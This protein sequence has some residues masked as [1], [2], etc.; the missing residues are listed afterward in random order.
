MAHGT[1]PPAPDRNPAAG[2]GASRTARPGRQPPAR[3]GRPA[4]APA[5]EAGGAGEMVDVPDWPRLIDGR[6]SSL[7]HRAE[8]A[9]S[10]AVV[11]SGL[12]RRHSPVRPLQ[13][14]GCCASLR[15]GLRP[16]LT[17]EPL[18]GLRA[19]LRAAGRLPLVCRAAR[20]LGVR[21]ADEVPETD[22]R[23]DGN[24]VPI[25]R[26]I[27]DRDGRSTSAAR[28]A[29]VPRGELESGRPARVRG[30]ESPRFRRLDQRLRATS[31]TMTCRYGP[32]GLSFGLSSRP[33]GSRRP[34]PRCRAGR[35][36]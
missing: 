26:T 31:P 20:A 29:A 25:H 23:A 13:R 33:T 4:P 17:P 24:L 30:F 2:A 5:K 1:S 16:P 8:P 34:G 3:P 14:Q 22:G 36:R 9:L 18:P 35:S 15:D 32:P 21:I 12:G 7:G 28:A 27:L 11:A 6:P 19:A 10:P